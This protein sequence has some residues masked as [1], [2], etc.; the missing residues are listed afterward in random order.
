MNGAA[1][2]TGL[3]V[4]VGGM[5]LSGGGQVIMEP[6]GYITGYGAGAT[7]TNFDNTIEGSGFIKSPLTIT[8]DAAGTINANHGNMLVNTGNTITNDGLIEA[9]STGILILR[10]TS[11]DSSGGGRVVDSRQIQ[12][13]NSTLTGGSLSVDAGGKLVSGKQGG[14]VSLGG[15]TVTNAGLIE[16]A[17][18]GLTVNGDVANNSLIEGDNGALTITG[19]V[20]GTGTANVF[21]KGSLEVDG[22]FS[23]NVRFAVGSTGSL[24]ISDFTGAVFGLSQTGKNQIDLKSLTFDATDTTSYSGTTAS[25]TLSILDS[26]S[27]V[28]ATINLVGNYVGSTFTLSDG[29][30]NGTIVKDPTATTTT[31]SLV[32]AMANFGSSGGHSAAPATVLTQAPHMIAMAHA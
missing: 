8:N 6:K 24:I 10:N 9:T 11:V 26:S 27:T 12:L 13:D 7:L 32:S 16:G 25:G 4:G 5:T 23:Q 20:T 3:V 31:N 28:V 19:A 17:L 14:T 2:F 30:A 15:A 29:G 1:A 22:A 18:G 21:G